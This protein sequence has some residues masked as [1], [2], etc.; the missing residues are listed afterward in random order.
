M[1]L[2]TRVAERL[3][4]RV[5]QGQALNT[6]H[7]NITSNQ[8]AHTMSE[9]RRAGLVHRPG[10]RH[11]QPTPRTQAALDALRVLNGENQ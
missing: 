4:T 3:L 2:D 11:Y 8:V 1:K 9:L 5:V 10:T 6:Q 7:D